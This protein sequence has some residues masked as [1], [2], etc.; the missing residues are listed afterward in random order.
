MRTIPFSPPRIDE[1]TI[2]AVNEVLRSG[3]ITTGPRTREFES[4][5][6]GYT[7]SARVL[8]LNSWTNAAE[9]ALRWFG[10]GPGD[11]VIVP[12]Y[13]YAASANII[14]H[15]GATPVFVDCE[16]GSF[17]ISAEQIRNALTSRT[18]AVMPVDVGGMPVDYSAISVVCEAAHE[19]FE[20]HTE[21]Q[22][23]LGRPLFLSDAA[24]SFG[25]RV[26]GKVLGYQADI[27][28]FSFHAVK[29]LTTAE[30]GAL[31]LNLPAPFNNDEVWQ[32]LAISGL[33][34]QTKDALAKSHAGQWEYDIVEAGYKCNMTDIQAAMG[35]VEIGRYESETLPRRRA[36][37]SF[38]STFFK[39]RDW[40]LLPELYGHDAETSH[41]LFMLRIDGLS[42][43]GRNAVIRM[44]AGK[45][46]SLNVHF[47]PLP[48]LTF[49]RTTF[50]LNESDFPNAMTQ[51]RNEISL[52]VY[53]DLSDEDMRYVAQTVAEC[54]E[55]E[56]G[57]S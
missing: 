56:L 4:L 10:I 34:G 40:A 11:E 17:L 42:E 1:R 30:G 7:G 13:T 22:N 32:A 57:R 24:H 3:W 35:V 20:A 15:L 51:F 52:P 12:V 8:C 47:Q 26:D 25:A 18:K 53:F 54:V 6:R 41:H 38:Y 31:A 29:N 19:L 9:L 27:T 14:V 48:R 2:E 39:D 50:R 46:V 36:I 45:G 21:A 28:A 23:M 44:A 16:K 49:Y 33:H 55:Y 5:I 43:E 37:T